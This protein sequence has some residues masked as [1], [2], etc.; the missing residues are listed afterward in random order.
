[1]KYSQTILFDILQLLKE[2]KTL[3][4]LLNGR[5]VKY[6]QNGDLPVFYDVVFW[7]LE[8]SPPV[9]ERI[10]TYNSYP[11]ITFTIN[12]SLIGWDSDASVS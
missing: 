2:M 3:D 7:R 5:K 8:A 9:F 11:E 1:M 12:N 6:D 10:G 4:F